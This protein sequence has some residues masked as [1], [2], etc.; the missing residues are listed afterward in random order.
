MAADRVSIRDYDG[1][2]NANYDA[3]FEPCLEMT[4]TQTLT[5]LAA[6]WHQD[7]QTYGA[8]PGDLG[9][10]TFTQLMAALIP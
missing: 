7:G 9:I 2:G 8:S 5:G 10:V 4:G 1:N 6:A 3:E